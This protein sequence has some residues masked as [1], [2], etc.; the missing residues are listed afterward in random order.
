MGLEGSWDD[1][2]EGAPPRGASM[3][4]LSAQS[5]EELERMRNAVFEREGLLVSLFSM[6]RVVP[7]RVLMLFK[8]NDLLRSVPAHYTLL[9][10]LLTRF[11]S[12]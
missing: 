12:Q 11:T 6:L 9:D 3:L 7:R 5:E 2:A 4:E 10:P 1:A 8:M